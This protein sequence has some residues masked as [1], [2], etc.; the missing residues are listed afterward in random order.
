MTRY[1]FCWDY[2]GWGPHAMRWDVCH[3]IVQEL[4]TELLHSRLLLANPFMPVVVV[5]VGQYRYYHFIILYD[6]ADFSDIFTR[7]F[8][9]RRE[10]LL[11]YDL[12]VRPALLSPCHPDPIQIQIPSAFT[13][14]LCSSTCGKTEVL[15]NDLIVVAQTW[16]G[17]ADLKLFCESF[18]NAR[19]VK[20]RATL[21]NLLPHLHEVPLECQLFPTIAITLVIAVAA[22]CVAYTYLQGPSIA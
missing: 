3:S 2:I 19:S 16:N 22:A 5:L 8:I 12:T 14:C 13:W 9:I 10:H 15:G 1:H 17:H 21:D 7:T 4:G 20:N 18:Q 6:A 11:A